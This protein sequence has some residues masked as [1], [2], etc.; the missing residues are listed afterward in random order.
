M[1]K[2]GLLI[3]YVLYKG[4]QEVQVILSNNMLKNFGPREILILIIIYFFGEII[5]TIMSTGYLNE[6]RMLRQLLKVKE[7]EDRLIFYFLHVITVMKEFT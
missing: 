6:N 4:V 3:I 1:I 2:I 5:Y 7:I